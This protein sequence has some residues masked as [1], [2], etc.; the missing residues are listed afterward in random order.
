[1]FCNFNEGKGP[2]DVREFL[3]G[4]WTDFLQRYD[5]ENA[6]SS[7]GL[8]INVP[9]FDDEA[10]EVHEGVPDTFDYIWVNLWGDQGERANGL[11]AVEEYGQSMMEAANEASTCVDE[12][13]WTGRRIKARS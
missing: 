2:E 6:N 1:M 3:A 12:Q 9:D 10:V 11:A 4:P 8:S 7:Y 5:S 13:V